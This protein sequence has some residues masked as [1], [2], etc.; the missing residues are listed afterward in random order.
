MK[1]PI[2]KNKQV[3]LTGHTGFKGAWLS[4]WLSSL[5][6]KVHGVALDP[7][8]E[9]NFYRVAKVASLLASDTRLDIRNQEA[10]N[11][12]VSDLQPEVVFHLAAQSLV[13]Y[14]YDFPIETYS[15]N[16]MGTAHVLEAIRRSESVR[17]AVVVTTDKCYENQERMIPYSE[18]D[19]LGGLDPYSNSKACAELLISAYRASY[20]SSTNSIC[21]ASARA[22]NVIGGGDWAANRLVPDCIRAYAS[23]TAMNLRY[24]QAIRPWQHVLESLQGYLLLA[25]KLLGPDGTRFAE[26]WNFGPEMDDMQT[27]GEVTSRIA[28]MLQMPIHLPEN[29]PQWHEASLLRLDSTKAKQRLNWQRRWKLQE[30]IE[31]TIAWYRCWLEGED[32]QNYSC[33]QLERYF[34][35]KANRWM[36]KLS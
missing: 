24:P 35:E 4:L 29:A 33:M 1:S 8:T 27:V 28:A 23:K 14:S 12:L 15:V 20:F 10:L 25:E 5:G 22:G 2:W 11:Q 3:L 6:A 21:L 19:R 36:N 7:P 13:H 26:S 17:A 16:V 9:P 18:S 34:L 30:A 31:E 32:M